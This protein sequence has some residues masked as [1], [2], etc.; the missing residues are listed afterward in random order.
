MSH[1]LLISHP[2]L[3]PIQAPLEGAGYGIV[4]RWEMKDGD[5]ERVEAIVH[6]GEIYLTPDFLETLPNL[7]LIANVSVGYDGVDVPWCRARGIEV[8]HADGLNAEDVADHALGLLIG[9][10]RNIVAGDRMIRSGVWNNDRMEV[11][12]GMKG[13]KVGI[14]GLGHIG[15]AV[16]KRVE[17]F[18]MS[19][20]WWG[21]NP[22]PDA[23]WP[24]AES[25]LALA[26]DCDILVVA[27]RAD[28]S[29]RQAVN[30][31][32]ID[33]VG[34][35]GMIV[36]V[37]RGSVIDEDALIAALKAGRLGRAGL[38]VFA[39]EPTPPERWEGVPNTVLTPHSAGGTVGSLPSMIAQTFENL[40][41]HFAGEALLSPA[42]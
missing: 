32:V 3:S 33:A 26:Q 23:A 41:R 30:A 39:T 38:D 17:A 5:T 18:G 36:N 19:V 4:R 27:C 42:A 31:A 10:W 13:Q 40:R 2:M 12:P 28:V 29:N 1:T 21:P 37:A 8:S 22:K 25:L 35:K 15:V 9:G 6:A 34:P 20:A 14:M 11:G 24:R 7:K 16:A